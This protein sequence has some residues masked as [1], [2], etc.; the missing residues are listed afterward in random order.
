MAVPVHIA[1]SRSPQ[2]V[3]MVEY[4]VRIQERNQWFHRMAIHP[5]DGAISVPT[6]PGLGIDL[7]GSRI[8]EICSRTTQTGVR[9]HIAIMLLTSEVRGLGSENTP[10]TVGCSQNPLTSG[11]GPLRRE[12]PQ[13]KRGRYPQQVRRLFRARAHRLTTRMRA[14]MSP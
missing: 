14:M 6:E 1:A 4:L 12:Y 13:V 11:N 3:P 2:A 9:S 5:V 8:A 7:D 10:R